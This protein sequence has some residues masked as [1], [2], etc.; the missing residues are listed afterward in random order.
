MK[1]YGVFSHNDQT[2]RIL[3]KLENRYA[4]F[5]GLNL[6]WETLEGVA[7]HNGPVKPGDLTPTI[8]I[9]SAQFDLE[10]GTFAGPEAQIAAIADDIAYNTHDFDDGYRA[11][12]FRSEDLA[13]LPLFGDALAA[14]RKLYPDADKERIIYETVREVIGL[15]VM[16][17]LETARRNIAALAPKSAQDVR[18][19][20]QTTVSFSFEMV[21][22]LDVLRSFLQA[23]MYRHSKVNRACAKAREIVKDLF[24]FFMEQPNCLPNAWFEA[25][26]AESGNTTHRARIIADYI[27]GMTDRYAVQEHRKLFS[28]ETMI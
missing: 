5:D 4:R 27:A 26:R 20:K 2:F 15:M 1:P 12:F 24:A 6:T 7:K 16:D 19:A 9:F 23:R 11:G 18:N 8:R 21:R 3:T 17:C 28:T 10:L 25:A 13:E 22:H 14:M